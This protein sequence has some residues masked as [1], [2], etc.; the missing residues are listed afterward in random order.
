MKKGILSKPKFLVHLHK[1][2]KR[3]K[4]ASSKATANILMFYHHHH[5]QVSSLSFKPSRA[6]REYEFSCSNTPNYIFPFNL[7]NKKKTG[8]NNYYHYFF[9]CTHA[10][11]TYDDDIAAANAFKVVLEMLNDENDDNNNV[12]GAVVAASPMLPD[13]GQTPLVRQLRVTDSPFPLSDA[14]EGN[15][16]V[17]K[18]ADDF[19][20]RFYKDLKLQNKGMLTS[21]NNFH[22]WGFF[23]VDITNKWENYVKINV[24][25][26]VG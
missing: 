7:P 14:D 21:V 12:I 23:A 9:A 18:A 1:L 10:P 15:D 8:I 16:N 20:I 2:L 26:I 25:V 17:D 24:F 13:F 4:I 22:V 5:H 19:I 11:R 3:G 6:V